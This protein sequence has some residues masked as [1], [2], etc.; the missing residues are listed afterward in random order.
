MGVCIIIIEKLLIEE[1]IP[2]TLKLKEECS[3]NKI[4]EILNATTKFF[5]AL[6]SEIIQHVHQNIEDEN[7]VSLM[8]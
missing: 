3:N 2:V 6:S 5:S 8:I 1:Q 4:L 7:A